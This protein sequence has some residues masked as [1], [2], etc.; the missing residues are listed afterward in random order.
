LTTEDQAEIRS[1]LGKACIVV[2]NS[3]V[4]DVKINITPH[5]ALGDYIL[6][7]NKVVRIGDWTIYG[8]VAVT[9]PNSARLIRQG[10]QLA[11]DISSD[12]SSQVAYITLCDYNLG[13]RMPFISK[14]V[15]LKS[16]SI[17]EIGRPTYG[18]NA[19]T[20]IVS[21]FDKDMAFLGYVKVVE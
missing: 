18:V 3:Y 1:K 11:L 10:N 5:S 6:G 13:P 4:D 7:L 9:L 16:H 17:V 21:L 19:S 20:S 15:D 8:N 12:I 2:R 14:T